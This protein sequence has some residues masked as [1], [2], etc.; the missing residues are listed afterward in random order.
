MVF[1]AC[2]ADLLKIVKILQQVFTYIKIFIPIALI[3]FGAI[4][5]GKAV[6][7][8]EEKEIKA[9]TQLLIKRAVAAAAVFLLVTIVGLVMTLVGG[10]EWKDCWKTDVTYNST[11]LL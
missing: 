10:T 11:N 7:A 4:D 3:L 9:A 2:D 5:L 8:G 1:L 6:M